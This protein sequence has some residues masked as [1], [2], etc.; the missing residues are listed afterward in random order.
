MELKDAVLTNPFS[1]NSM[2]DAIDQAIDMPEDERR[3][4]MQRLLAHVKQ[5]D[6]AYWTRHVM[7]KFAKLTAS[8]Q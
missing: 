8:A 3:A 1:R 7:A 2:D 6:I 4:R 5:Y